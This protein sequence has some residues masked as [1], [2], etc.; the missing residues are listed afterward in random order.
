[1]SDSAKNPTALREIFSRAFVAI[2]LINF[3]GM[4]GYYAVFVVS[5]KYLT[6]V[7]QTG[8]AV[9]G[10]AAGIVV[11]GCLVGRFFTG[12]VVYAA[13]F[14][15][16]LFAGVLLYFL[17]GIAYFVAHN[18]P[19]LFLVRFLSGSAIGII[20]TAT[21]TIV[22]TIVRPQLHGQA[23]AYFSM[24]TALALCFGPFVGIAL[25]DSL[26]YDGIF[27]IGAALAAISLALLPLARTTT[28]P[29]SIAPHPFT[30]KDYIEP[31]LVPL[32]IFVCAICFSWGNVQA[33]LASYAHIY[34]VTTAASFFFLVYAVAI[35]VSRPISGKIYDSHGAPVVLYP[36]LVCLMLG[37]VLLGMNWGTVSV[38]IA[39]M[40]MGLGFGNFQSITQTLAISLVPRSRYPQ[41]TSTFFIFFDLGVGI[42]PF[43]AGNL[44]ELVGYAHI[45]TLN[46]VLVALCIGYY[47]WLNRHL[48]HNPDVGQAL[49]VDT[50][51]EKLGSKTAK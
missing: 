31:S 14:T 30:I 12:R 15:K 20:G 28:P 8:A 42:A 49:F 6:E 25:L 7:F 2:S 29:R 1:M 44:V 41:A 36:A 21:G 33:F 48:P 39:G 38:L 22:P 26:G 24:S 40:L 45:F 17:T 19:V 37:L 43:L 23:I 4:T 16:V 10:L 27:A 13:G 35:L 46:G 3:F 11:I 9:G 47:T 32:A 50:Q 18:L 34:H 5:A 51:D